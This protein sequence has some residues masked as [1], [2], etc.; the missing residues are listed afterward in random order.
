MLKLNIYG[1]Y[2]KGRGEEERKGDETFEFDPEDQRSWKIL[3]DKRKDN[4]KERLIISKSHSFIVF[5]GKKIFV[6]LAS[7]GARGP[8]DVACYQWLKHKVIT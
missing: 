1:I 3:E 7:K 5:S 6:L 2:I 8:V 4:K